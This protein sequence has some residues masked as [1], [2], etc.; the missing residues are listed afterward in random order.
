MA[1][2]NQSKK[3]EGNLGVRT[4]LNGAYFIGVGMISG[5]MGLATGSIIVFLICFG[6]LA[7]A[8]LHAGSIRVNPTRR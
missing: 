6:L 7:A 4:K 1:R 2:L 5:F 8:L 3:K